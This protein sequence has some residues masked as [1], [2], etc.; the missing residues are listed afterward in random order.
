MKNKGLISNWLALYVAIVGNKTVSQAIYDLGI[1]VE[2]DERKSL[3]N[4][5]T[6]EVREKIKETG[7]TNDIVRQRI[8][9]GWSLEKAIT[10]P[11]ISK[12]KYPDWVYENA[13]I[14]NISLTTLS[15]RIKNNWELKDA[16]T[17]PIGGKND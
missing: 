12:R 6:E 13:K 15:N 5:F 1:T 16:C 14:N 3:K 4:I 9:D 10:T 8:W 11:K 2:H 7:I 17:C